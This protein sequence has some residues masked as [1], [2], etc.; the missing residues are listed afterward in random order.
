MPPTTA[1]TSAVPLEQLMEGSKPSL[2]ELYRTVHVPG[3]CY[4]L[5]HGMWYDMGPFLSRHPGGRAALM[6]GAGRDATALFES[7]HVFADKKKVAAV[8]A[9]HRLSDDSVRSLGLKTLDSAVQDDTDINRHVAWSFD[10]EFRQAIVSRVRSHFEAEARRRGLSVAR[11]TKAT[12]TKWALIVS[13]FFV[14]LG[15]IA[16]LVRG[17]WPFIVLTPLTGWF[18]GVN[19]FHDALHFSLSSNPT[20]NSVV[21]AMFP[22]FASPFA[23][24]HQHMIGHH[25][26]TNL[27][28]LDPDLVHGTDIRRDHAAHPLTVMHKRQSRFLNVAFHFVVGTWLGLGLANDFKL[29]FSP[30]KSYNG[31]TPRIPVSTFKLITHTIS[32]I[33]Y[34]FLQFGWPFWML[35]EGTWFITRFAYSILPAMVF[36]VLFMVNT[37][38][39]HLTPGAMKTQ[40]LDWT[41]HQIIT[42]QNFGDPEKG[43]IAWWFH[44][45][46]SGGL[47]LQM[48]HHLFPTV[49]HCHLTA[50]SKIVKATCIEYGV[51]YTRVSGYWEGMAE[52][53]KHTDNMTRDILPSVT[54]TSTS[55]SSS[56]TSS[57]EDASRDSD[58]ESTIVGASDDVA[59]VKDLE[60][61]K[62]D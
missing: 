6:L 22:F 3:S 10:S 33:I 50:V 24:Y 31:F 61:K 28:Y 4:V 17:N 7:G 21:G 51:P 44:L 35:P 43:G 32:R 20:V 57:S 38:I 30:T 42:A 8:L 52:Y 55:S 19:C 25:V 47:N 1:S 40:S 34:Y 45:L 9:K 13:T 53:M 60:S 58:E 15:C 41:I 56:S 59:P 62:E 12:P 18:C 5:V 14:F 39:N 23:W 46:F 54:T 36:S 48:E 16:M 2:D 49:N 27:E 26:H 37:Q 29:I 11:A